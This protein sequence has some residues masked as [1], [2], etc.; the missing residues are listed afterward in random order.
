MKP[1]EVNV[2]IELNDKP[3]RRTDDPFELL[4]SMFTYFFVQEI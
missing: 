3:S 4:V 1:N 2:R